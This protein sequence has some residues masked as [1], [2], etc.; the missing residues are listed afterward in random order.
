M[1]KLVKMGRYV[2]DL[3]HIILQY[4]EERDIIVT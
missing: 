3:I 2:G 4:G 1:R